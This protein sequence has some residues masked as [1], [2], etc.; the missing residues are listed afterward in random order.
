ML[1]TTKKIIVSLGRPWIIAPIT[2]LQN[3]ERM[4][5]FLRT[6]FKLYLKLLPFAFIELWSHIGIV[7]TIL[8]MRE[9]FLGYFLG[10]IFIVY[11]IKNQFVSCICTSSTVVLL[12]Q[13]SFHHR[14]SWLI[15]MIKDINFDSFLRISLVFLVNFAK[16]PL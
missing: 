4:I 5:P 1:P 6:N 8:Y 15:E 11:H 14:R 12:T 16:E 3:G 9:W 2:F 7:N 13:M 10:H